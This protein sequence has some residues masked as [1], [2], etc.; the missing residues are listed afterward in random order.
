MVVEGSKR[1]KTKNI[2]EESLDNVG[3]K[4]M[5][6]ID[7]DEEHGLKLQKKKKH[8]DFTHLY[9]I[10]NEQDM[11]EGSVKRFNWSANQ[12]IDKKGLDKDKTS[13]TIDQLKSEEIEIWLTGV[14]GFYTM[15]R[16]YVRN[17]MESG[18]M[19]LLLNICVFLN[20]MTLA[21][22]GLVNDDVSDVF[23]L[24]N[25]VFTMFFTIEMVLKLYGIGIGKYMSDAFNIMD[26]FIVTISMAELVMNYIAT[27]SLN[28]S[29]GSS[30]VSALRSVRV[31]RT[32]RVL[33]VTRLLRSLR[34]MQ[35]II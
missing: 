32:F 35:I 28:P 34:Y 8:V 2:G 30:A 1:L 33:R 14:S 12:I 9:E 7:L 16:R 24:M 5:R 15:S 29:G 23:Q 6:D 11:K 3:E 4:F 25:F 10:I 19:N 31:F 20:T 17:F 26:G 27:G 18:F 22:Q 13:Y 21:L